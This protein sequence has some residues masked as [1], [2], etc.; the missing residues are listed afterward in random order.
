MR[1]VGMDKYK[2]KLY[3][4]FEIAYNEERP[5]KRVLKEAN[6]GFVFQALQ[7]VDLDSSPLV[8]LFASDTSFSGKHQTHHPNYS[9]CTLLGCIA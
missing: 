5:P 9:M 1:M 4:Q 6:S 3:T 2:G 8:L 7:A